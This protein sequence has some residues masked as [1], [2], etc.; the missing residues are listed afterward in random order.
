MCVSKIT[1]LE[2]NNTKCNML[3]NFTFN[4]LKNL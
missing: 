2:E 1:C 3:N 4:H